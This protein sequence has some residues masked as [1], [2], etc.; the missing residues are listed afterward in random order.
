M[1]VD[2]DPNLGKRDFLGKW[3]KIGRKMAKKCLHRVLKTTVF[4]DPTPDYEHSDFFSG[5]NAI[6]F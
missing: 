5:K 1:D 6:V 3:Q 2:F 4:Q